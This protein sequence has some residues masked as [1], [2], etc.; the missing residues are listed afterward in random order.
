M[1]LEFITSHLSLKSFFEN[2]GLKLSSLGL[3]SL[4][5]FSCG[6]EIKLVKAEDPPPSKTIERCLDLDGDQFYGQEECGTF[7]DCHD[8]DA[9][10]WQIQTFYLDNDQ[11]GY[12]FGS[13]VEFCA[14]FRPEGFSRNND[15][16][17]DAN[18]YINQASK[19]F[20]NGRDDDCNIL[21]ADGDYELVLNS[22]QEGVCKHSLQRCLNSRMQDDYHLVIDYEQL[23]QLC[24]NLD[25][26]CDGDIDETCGKIVFQ[27]YDSSTGISAIKTVDW[28]GSGLLP[29][30][31]S[32]EKTYLDPSWS[33]DRKMLVYSKYHH[34]PRETTLQLHDLSSQISLPIS[35]PV[36]INSSWCSN[37]LI[38]FVRNYELWS[39]NPAGGP[40]SELPITFPKE[41]YS[42]RPLNYRPSCS[43]DSRQIAFTSVI[44]ENRLFP[45][46]TSQ[47]HY[48]IKTIDI[49]G[50]VN[51]ETTRIITEH[52]PQQRDFHNQATWSPDGQY[53]VI[54]SDREG[55]RNQ[56]LFLV[57]YANYNDSLDDLENIER[58]TEDLGSFSELPELATYDDL[59]PCLSENQRYLAFISKSYLP[60][61][62][63]FITAV[64][65]YLSPDG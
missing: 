48:F 24:D 55:P 32:A 13:P 56:E 52:W 46:R 11:D 19:E 47:L 35:N 62:I 22:K 38:I 4:L 54:S 3:S 10:K 53:L 37:G 64:E 36:A 58:L 18:R 14:G 51:N 44:T 41:T 42:A 15:D 33:P 1:A 34:H 25:N 17:D 7:V 28:D 59:R 39:V 2:L 31:S 29:I 49:N 12:G 26:D 63:R 6:E 57:N 16:C 27:H 23:E 50:E 65:E 20:C 8:Q 61:F 9:N 5:L 21:T 43:P 60:A 45:E 30:V 40:D